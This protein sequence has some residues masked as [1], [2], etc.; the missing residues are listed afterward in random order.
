[1]P[2]AHAGYGLPIG[3]VLATDNAVIP[4]A[5]GVDIGCRM[6]LTVFDAKADY[7]KRYSHQIK[8]ALKD[9]TH[10]GMEGGLTFAQEHEVTEREEFQL[11]PLLRD[12]RWKGHPSVGQ[13]RW[14]KSFRGVRRASSARRKCAGT[15]RRQ[16]YGIAVTFRFARTWS[17]Y[18]HAL[19]PDSPE[20]CKL[21]REAQHFAWLDLN[22]EEGQEYWMSMN[23]A[24]DYARA[25]HEQIHL[26]LSKALG[27]KPMANVNN[28]HNFAWKEDCTGRTAIVHRKGA[29][30][31]QAGQPGLI[32]EVW[33]LPVIW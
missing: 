6:S 30:P 17:S 25:C 23:L 19:Q 27:L 15:A 26:N 24:G 9:Y 33:Q 2:D 10:F 20:V 4:Y 28:H 7:L 5:V 11:T 22:S 16:L 32:P 8:E 18:C 31:A 21:P 29:T 1:M 3:G 12:L 14:W 13:F